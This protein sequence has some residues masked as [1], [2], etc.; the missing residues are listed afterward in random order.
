MKR[1]LL[2]FLI[3]HGI[4]FSQN[5]VTAKLIKTSSI[6]TENIIDIDNFDAKYYR[7][8]TTL[9][10]TNQNSTINY[11]NIQLGNIDIIDTFNPLKILLFYKT[12]NTL[13]IL[14]NRLAE[15]FKIDFSTIP[16]YK[17]VSHISAGFDNTLWVFNT[18]VQQL[19]LYDYKN[20]STRVKT[21]PVQSNILAISSNYNYCWLLTEKYLYRY[22]YMGSLLKKIPNSDFTALTEANDNLILQSIDGLYFLSKE[23]KVPLKIDLP[24]LLI[25][26]FFVTNETLYIYDSEKL[27]EFQLTI[28]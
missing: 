5:K 6:N 25:N 8:I 18:D 16:D 7:N 17:N 10:K 28:N 15:I 26:R 12:F 24:E 1:F 23:S 20:K 9:Y 4:A 3:F 22:N 21:L 27:H 19:Q 14:D 11:S 2:L 13:I